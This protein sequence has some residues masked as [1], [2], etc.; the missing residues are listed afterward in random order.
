[1]S[2]SISASPL[3]SIAPAPGRSAS[4]AQNTEKENSFLTYGGNGVRHKGKRGRV[5]E[6]KTPFESGTHLQKGAVPVGGEPAVE[7]EGVRCGSKQQR[8]HKREQLLSCATRIPV[9]RPPLERLHQLHLRRH[10]SVEALH[11]GL[12]RSEARALRALRRRAVGAHAE[13]RKLREG[14]AVLLPELG[15]LQGVWGRG[16][17]G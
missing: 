1:M 2:S 6:F 3:G 11:R 10:R 4:Y 12:E 7:C 13:R 15:D 16:R 14:E 8:L 17:G 9:R 5:G